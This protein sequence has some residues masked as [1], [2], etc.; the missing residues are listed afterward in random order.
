MRG[1]TASP[2][3]GHLLA[4]AF[5]GEHDIDLTSIKGISAEALRIA[6]ES[7]A[8]HAARSITL[9]PGNMS[10]TVEELVEVLVESGLE[11]R[12]FRKPEKENEQDAGFALYTSLVQRDG[13]GTRVFCA[14]A[15]CSDLE[16]DLP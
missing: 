6:V 16:L 1:D 11:A 8:S 15:S 12:I 4:A 14:A 5:E 3:V 10:S 13:F 2:A 9:V 7:E